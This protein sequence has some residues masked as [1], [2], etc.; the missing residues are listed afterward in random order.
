MTS[1]SAVR[2]VIALLAA[3]IVPIAT[4]SAYLVLSRHWIG[5][6]TGLGDWVAIS[7]AVL[8]GAA[9]LY[10]WARNCEWSSGSMTLRYIAVGSY[11]VV[12]SAFLFFYALYFVCMAF[13][14]CL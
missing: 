5:H 11:V 14:A 4:L 9:C 6:F 10:Q 7:V 2:A 8:L 13:G 12:A 1:K 3:V